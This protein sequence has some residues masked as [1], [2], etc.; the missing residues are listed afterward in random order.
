MSSYRK[1]NISLSD[2]DENSSESEKYYENIS[3]PKRNKAHSLNPMVKANFNKTSSVADNTRNNM[4]TY[5]EKKPKRQP[6]CFSRN[7]LMARENRLKKKMYIQNL[8]KDVSLLKSDNKKMVGIVEKQSCLIN[9]LKKEVKYLKSVLANSSDLSRLIKNIHQGTGMSV[10]TSLDEHLTLKNNCVSKRIVPVSR[11][12][13]HPWEDDVMHSSSVDSYSPSPEPVGSD[14]FDAF[15]TE[16]ILKDPYKA[17]TSGKPLSEVPDVDIADG[18]DS[19]S[20]PFLPNLQENCT[21]DLTQQEHNY[22]FPQNEVTD[23]AGICLHVSKHKVSLEFCPTCSENASATW[24][25]VG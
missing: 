22:T 4:D 3:R 6:K 20:L 25:K 24:Q 23:D 11:K 5:L 12:T 15:I 16:D 1:R 8:E 17:L 9:E 13:A 10:A 21:S 18:D 14:E 7:A 19:Y 2:S